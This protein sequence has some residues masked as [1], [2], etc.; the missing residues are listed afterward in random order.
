MLKINPNFTTY[1]SPSFKSNQRLVFDSK[2]VLH[3]Q[4]STVFFRKDLNWKQFVRFL[5]NRFKD[6]DKV[7]LCATACS[8]G[9]EPWSLAVMLKEQ[10]GDEADKFF[11]IMASDFDPEIIQQA[12]NAPCTISSEDSILLKLYT[13]GNFDKYFEHVKPSYLDL[14]FSVMK[15]AVRPTPYMNSLVNFKVSDITKE[16][17]NIP[18]ENSVVL[19]R[20]CW[21]Y[22]SVPKR[23]EVAKALSNQLGESS[24]VVVGELEYALNHDGI[25]RD[26][27]F[28]Q[29]ALHNVFEKDKF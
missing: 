16:I 22:F 15:G 26:N 14:D 17:E 19:C 12:Q 8:D 27:G 23:Q 11:P 2:G 24:L 7:N 29:T 1:N 21:R 9:S 20:N 5:N 10:F 3:H 13:Q 6:V 28:R 18:P 25:L 4:N